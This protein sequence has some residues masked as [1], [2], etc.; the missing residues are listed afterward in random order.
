MHARRRHVRLILILSDH[1]ISTIDV[2]P[3]ERIVPKCRTMRQTDIV[4]A[5]AGLAGS[6]AAAMLSRAGYD[7]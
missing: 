5:G 2:T 1:L 3:C 6:T 7:V 4:I